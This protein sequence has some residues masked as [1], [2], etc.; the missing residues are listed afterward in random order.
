MRRSTALRKYLSPEP[1]LQ[2]PAHV[3]RMARRGVLL[4][5]YGYALNSPLRHADPTG[6]APPEF[7]GKPTCSALRIQDLSSRFSRAANGDVCLMC[8]LARSSMTNTCE[9][10]GTGRLSPGEDPA[11]C[12]CWAELTDRWCDQ[13]DQKLECREVLVCGGEQ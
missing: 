4:S 5:A 8:Q 12:N 11:D 7:P 2:S 10:W 6:L 3:R 9:L 1:L 13:A